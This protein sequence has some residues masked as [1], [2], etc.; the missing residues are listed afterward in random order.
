MAN[1]KQ[2]HQ[3]VEDTTVL[4]EDDAALVVSADGEI[5]FVMPDYGEDEEVPPLV[6]ALG[7]LAIKLQDEEFVEDLLSELAEGED[8]EGDEI[9]GEEEDDSE[10]EPASREKN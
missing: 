6:A 1:S 2:T 9:E 5:S 8:D 3:T 10:Q 4:A 7:L